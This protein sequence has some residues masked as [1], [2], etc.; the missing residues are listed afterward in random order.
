MNIRCTGEP[1]EDTTEHSYSHDT[2]SCVCG[3]Q[4]VYYEDPDPD[5]NVGE[6]CE[7]AGRVWS[8]P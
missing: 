2:D 1:A 5:G 7:V 8:T 4:V 6:G 3:G